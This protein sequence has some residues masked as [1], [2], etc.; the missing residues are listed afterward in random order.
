MLRITTLAE[1]HLML[2]TDDYSDQSSE[3]TEQQQTNATS[4]TNTFEIMSSSA[5]RNCLFHTLN[6]LV[7]KG[8]LIIKDLRKYIC[9]Y[10]ILKETFY[11]FRRWYYRKLY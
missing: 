8:T 4:I 3:E 11:K 10:I 5:D 1:K 6:N 9:C 7:F 2:F